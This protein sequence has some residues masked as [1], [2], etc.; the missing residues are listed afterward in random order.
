MHE[1]DPIAPYYD[2]EHDDFSDDADLYLN[3]I[4]EG[5]VLEIGAGTG[6]LLAVLADAG[7]EMWGVEPSSSMRERGEGR[8]AGHPSAHLVSAIDHLPD[9][10]RFRACVF[11]LNTLWHFPGVEDQL[12]AVR[13][14][15]TRLGTG[16]S[17][18]VDTSNPLTM[19]DRDATGEVRQ[20]F[21]RTEGD[22]TV[23]RY[24]AAWDEP[25]Q[26]TLHL[27]LTFV[28]SGAE[29]TARTTTAELDLRY[30]Y[31]WELELLLRLA[32]FEVIAVYGSYDLEPFSASSP[33]IVV[34]ARAI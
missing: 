16:G 13:Q 25:A 7:L 5:P 3:L 6:R 14:A 24:A 23:T 31:R 30:L 11:G 27:S 9:G 2:L 33:R 19:A 29:G 17:L 26:Q 15:R 10:M 32:H 12:Q 1:Y 34:H 8:L 21:R 28:T 4:R 18:F 22:H 20:V